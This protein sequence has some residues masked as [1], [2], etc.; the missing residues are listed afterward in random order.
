[1]NVF[2]ARDWHPPNHMPFN[3]F[4]DVWPP[5]CVQGINEAEF[6]PDLIPPEEVKGI[7]KATDPSKESYS[8][9]DGTE[10]EEELRKKGAGSSIQR[11]N[12][13]TWQYN[14]GE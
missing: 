7:S 3:P 2:A 11:F 1:M 8:G 13:L 5:H 12:F 10:S 14:I 4:W 9:V 6:H